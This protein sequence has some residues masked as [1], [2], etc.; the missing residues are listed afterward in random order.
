MD[1]VVEDESVG[2]CVISEIKEVTGEATANNRKAKLIFLY[3]WNLKLE[4]K[5][6]CYGKDTEI[7][8]SIEIPNLSD[9]NEAHEVDVTMSCKATSKEADL[10]LGLMK[11]RGVD[12]V[13]KKIQEYMRLLRQEYA[14][15]LI[16]PTKDT[17]QA[18]SKPAPARISKSSEVSRVEVTGGHV[19]VGV[20][21]LSETFHCRADELFRALTLPEMVTAFTQS[22]AEVEPKVGGNFSLFN[23]ELRGFNLM[24]TRR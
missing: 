12:E 4:W 15:D 22:K 16:L 13:Q 11:R 8:G 18:S 10:L 3:D 17:K 14:K 21:E 2:R 24:T 5:G 23:G 20:I 19:N 7:K 9:E 6:K 1:L